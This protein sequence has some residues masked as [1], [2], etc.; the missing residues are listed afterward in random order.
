MATNTAWATSLLD[1]AAAIVEVE[2][3]RLQQGAALSER[4]SAD[5][6]AEMPAPR[7]GPPRVSATTTQRRRPGPPMPEDPRRWP[8]REWPPRRRYGLPPNDLL[9]RPRCPVR[10]A[11]SDS[12]GDATPMITTR[13]RLLCRPQTIQ[14]SRHRGRLQRAESAGAHATA[15]RGGRFEV[16]RPPRRCQARAGRGTASGPPWRPPGHSTQTSTSDPS[17]RPGRDELNPRPIKASTPY[18]PSHRGGSRSTF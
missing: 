7:P 16:G 4:E 9:R 1:K 8:T 10:K 15:T 11:L 2:W 12:G 6:S 18:G 5:L 17:G 3:T 14:M 13:Q